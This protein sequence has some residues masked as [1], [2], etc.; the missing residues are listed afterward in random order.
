MIGHSSTPGVGYNWDTGTGNPFNYYTQ[1][2]ACAEVEIDCL[3]GDHLVSPGILPCLWKLPHPAPRKRWYLCPVG[4]LYFLCFTVSSQVLRTDIVMDVGTSLNPA[5]DIGQIE[6]AFVQVSLRYPMD[7]LHLI[8]MSC[9]MNIHLLIQGY[10]LFTLEEQRYSPDGFL[11]TRG[12]GAYK[13]PGFT[14]IPVE[15]NVSLLKGASN[16]KAVYSSKV[17]TEPL[18]CVTFDWHLGVSI[19]TGHWW[20]TSLPVVLCVLCH[21]RGRESGAEGDWT[22]GHFPFR[23][24]RHGGENPH[25]MRRSIHRAGEIHAKLHLIL[26]DYIIYWFHSSFLSLNRE[27]ISHGSSTFEEWWKLSLWQNIFYQ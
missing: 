2:A 23:Q 25:G 12:P 1:G 17:S 19:I 5:I 15:F 18:I 6:G 22:R 16:P 13:I 4:G 21:Q 7:N 20:T 26:L 8:L 14:D 9:S 11:Y 10:G 24:S 3:T 27:P